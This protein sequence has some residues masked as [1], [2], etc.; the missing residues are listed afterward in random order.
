MMPSS[1][2]YFDRLR[3][4]KGS[5]SPN[6]NFWCE[7][8][9]KVEALTQPVNVVFEKSQSDPDSVFAQ[10]H[11]QTTWPMHFR[12][13]KGRDAS[14]AIENFSGTDSWQN[15]EEADVT[16]EIISTLIENG[17]APS[18]IGAMSPFRG[19][20]ALIRKLLRKKYYHDVNVG[21]IENYQAVE[22]DVIVLS[23]T[24]SN[25]D[26]VSHDVEKRMGIFGQPKQLNV[27]MTRAENLFIVV[28]NPD[29]M[30]N[31]PCWRQWLRFCCRNGVWFGQ[32]LE[33]WNQVASVSLKDMKFVSMLDLT[34]RPSDVNNC[35]SQVVVSTLEKIHRLHQT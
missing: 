21:T 32:G 20:V 10:I 6:L 17:V 34:E 23:L 14:I 27:A 18:T 16:V 30:W 33:Q 25:S 8:L 11:R 28:G 26:F 1:F 12:G 2:F 4:F 35:N 19:Q 31:D 9:R 24:R 5:N 13:V 22:Q 7:Q 15:A 3:S 29:V